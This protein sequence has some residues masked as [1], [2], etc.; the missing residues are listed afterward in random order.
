[1][2]AVR[3]EPVSAVIS[4]LTGKIQGNFA[5]SVTIWAQDCETIT[6]NQ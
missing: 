4:L 2:Q 1:M 6:L 5:R 3:C